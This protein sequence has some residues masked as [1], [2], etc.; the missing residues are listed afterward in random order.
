[1]ALFAAMWTLPQLRDKRKAGTAPV[2]ASGSIST[3]RGGQGG[4]TVDFFLHAEHDNAA[5][6]DYLGQVILGNGT[7]ILSR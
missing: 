6:H 2:R 5:A 4:Y 7:R 1:M 3:V